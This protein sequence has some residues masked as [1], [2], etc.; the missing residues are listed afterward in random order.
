MKSTK[1]EL[2]N[3]IKTLSEED[4]RLFQSYLEGYR[5]HMDMPSIEEKLILRDAQL[6]LMF[7]VS[8]GLS[9]EEAT[10]RLS[11]RNLG[12]FYAHEALSW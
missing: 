11:S 1:K 9:V 10:E 12:G 7:L 5:E 2:A 4:N 8:A 6:A 3:F